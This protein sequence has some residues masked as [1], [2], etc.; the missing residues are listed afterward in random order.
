M[1]GIGMRY[2]LVRILSLQ[3][4]IESVAFN[5]SVHD[6]NAELLQIYTDLQDFDELGSDLP[7]KFQSMTVLSEL[8]S[9][10][11]QFPKRLTYYAKLLSL[12][13]QT[14]IKVR[15]SL[16]RETSEVRPLIAY[17]RTVHPAS[18]HSKAG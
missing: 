11:E 10:S 5:I 3:D 17:T 13:I 15:D 18:N 2:V 16:C 12:L 9:N 8:M 6:I 4:M 7:N 14:E 1:A